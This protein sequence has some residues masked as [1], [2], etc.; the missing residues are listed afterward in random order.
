MRGSRSGRPFY[1]RTC[2]LPSPTCLL[3]LPC[4]PCQAWL[5]EHDLAVGALLELHGRRFRLTRADAFTEQYR[6]QHG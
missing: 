3:P 4:A 2:L 6:A 5:T 1:L